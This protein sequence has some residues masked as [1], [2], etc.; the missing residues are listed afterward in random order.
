[1]PAHINPPNI[2]CVTIF[3][4]INDIIDSVFSGAIYSPTKSNIVTNDAADAMISEVK[5]SLMV[6]KCFSPVAFLFN[7]IT[8][9]YFNYVLIVTHRYKIC[10]ISK[11]VHKVIK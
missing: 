3:E 11:S 1:M 6:G 7:G 4:Q 9:L 5:P 10:N 2:Q 8:S